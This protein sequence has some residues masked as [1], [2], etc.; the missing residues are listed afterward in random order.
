[1]R[2]NPGRLI[3]RNHA[4]RAA[5]MT[6]RVPSS[7]RLRVLTTLVL[8]LSLALVALGGVVHTTGSSLA[9]PD[10]PLCHG[11]VMPPMEGGILYEHSHRLLA[12]AVMIGVLAL[13][14]VAA[15]ASRSQR[16]LAIVAAGLVVV[17]AL[18]GAIT[19]LLRLPPLVSVLH[20]AGATTLC[21]LLAWIA[22]RERGPRAPIAR[23]TRDAIRSALVIVVA[24]VLLGAAVRHLGASMAC[25][26]DLL[27][28]DGTLAPSHALGVIHLA[29]R[30]LGIV[31]L[32]LVMR[33]G[34]LVSRERGPVIGLALALAAPA[35][36]ALGLLTV[37]LGPRL[38]IVASHL[39]LGELVVIG[40]V[41][42]LARTRDLAG[43]APG[44]AF[45]ARALVSS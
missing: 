45:V 7:E 9:C 42:L 40:L 14:W 21:A 34:V 11:E 30:A 43:A 6:G 5:G 29:H 38:A 44:H 1:M 16:H 8:V 27:A 23:R 24:Q 4:A 15:R 17:Q 10:W 22:T 3:S 19:V 37:A 25:G 12:L 18:L 35:Q 13:P 2:R 36:V 41:H 39:V 33:V 28:C 32:V 31:A 20:L 26:R